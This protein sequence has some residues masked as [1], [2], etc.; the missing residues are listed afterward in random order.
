MRKVSIGAAIAASLLLMSAAMPAKAWDREHAG[1]FAVLPAG[2]SG[3]EGLTVGPDGNIYVTTFGFNSAGAVTGTG[4]LFVYA[5][6]GKL[7]RHVAIAGSSVHLLGMA[8]NPATRTVQN[9]HLGDLIV[10]DFGAGK[11]LKVNPVTGASSVF[12][13]APVLNSAGPGLNGLTFDHAGN[14]YISDSFQGVI[15]KTG[16]AGGTPTQWLNDPLLTTTGTPPFGAN[17]IEFN[18]AGTTAFIANTGNDTVIAVPVLANGGAGTPAV[19]VNSI[20]GADGIAI[21][22]HDNLW[23]AANQAD[24]MVV[25]NPHGKV[26]AKL[27]DFNGVTD[28]GQPRGLLFPASPA[29]S[30]D[31][32]FLYV[33]NLALDI[34]VLG[35]P[36]AVDSQWA[37]LVN[38]YTIARIPTQ[39][40]AVTDGDGD[41]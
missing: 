26:I 21:D 16:P 38:H 27:G 35:L 33:T 28:A 14:V 40:P 12:M 22:A 4:Q 7:L 31:G 39:L 23:V 2:S 19:F 9:G 13:T 37:H 18:H 41:E 6:S 34:T 5:P 10:L 36:Q 29:F 30:L 3:P 11:A 32:A 15:W 1:T 8:F 17:G 24:E 25:V 20:N